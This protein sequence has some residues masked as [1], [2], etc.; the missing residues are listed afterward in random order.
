MSALVTQLCNRLHI[1][2]LKTSPSH[3]QTNGCIER[4]H[5]TLSSMIRKSIQS[6]LNWPEQVM[7]TLF[8]LRVPR[9]SNVRVYGKRFVT[10][11]RLT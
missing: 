1:D 8:A 3:P 5:G 2:K 10:K 11:F 9:H 7:Y 6:K 4:M